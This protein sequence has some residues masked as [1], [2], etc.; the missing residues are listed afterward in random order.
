M[1]TIASTAALLSFVAMGAPAS[2][3]E[4]APADAEASADEQDGSGSEVIE[5]ARS[6]EPG[7][8]H[9]V[10]EA[11]L[12]RF[13]H[14]DIHQILATVPGVYFREE[15][16][17]GLRPNIGMRGTD[18][19]R[20]AKV[21]LMEDGILIAPAPYS[22]PAAYYFPLVTRMSAVEVVKGPGTVVYGPNTVGG[23][24]NLVSQEVPRSGHIGFVDVAGGDSLYGK[25]HARYGMATSY[26][27]FLVEG[28]KL[29]SN[30]FKD[31]DG[32]GNTGF[33][34]TDLV[35]KGRLQSNPAH[36][37]FH[38]VNLTI[39]YADEDSNETYTG[40]SDDDFAA[41][42]YRRYRGTALDHMS[43]DHLRWQLSHRV[44]IGSDVDVQTTLY[45]NS[46]NRAWRKLNGFRGDSDLAGILANPDAG[47]N[48]IF[49]G[50]LRGDSDTSSAAEELLIGTNDRRFVSQGLQTV[51]HG[52]KQVWPGKHDLRLGVRLH[53][54]QADRHHSEDP[55]AMIGGELMSAGTTEI[56]TDSLAMASA[57]ATFLQD[58]IAMG[59]VA[60]TLG[61]RI[62]LVSTELVDRMMAT[63]TTDHYFV[64]I[65]GA[66]AYYKVVEGVGL[67]AGVHKGFVPVAPGAGDGVR[68]ED[69]LNYETGVRLSRWG[70][71][72]EAIGFFT[73]YRNLK[74]SCTFS[75]G[76]ETDQLGQEFN[77]GA[78]HTLG[79]E[80]MIQ[81][82]PAIAPELHLLMRGSY[83]FTRSTFQSDFE[84]DNPQWGSVEAGDYLPYLPQ[85]QLSGTMGLQSAS[86]ELSAALRFQ[87]AMRNHAG[88]G[89]IPD[90]E[91]IPAYAVADL[92][93]SYDFGRWGRAYLT[94]DNVF[95]QPY[96]VSYR[97]YGAR[98]GKPRIA[99]LGYKNRF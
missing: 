22:A 49:F 59:P 88:Q 2:A 83:T 39:G 19:E 30:G 68:P 84:S 99:I 12:E 51:I 28:V 58:Q 5:V 45:R 57:A 97:P 82:S 56:T 18:P 8:E 75:S 4:Q 1:R 79:V 41:N 3:D 73:D 33:D 71:G 70:I 63:T 95:D 26:A 69:S 81:A 35:F 32:G 80:S 54:D 43:W 21:A 31:L 20:S 65:P 67:L 61:S 93:G 11:E 98:P 14:D 91:R 27:G 72:A 25:L 17:F 47:N 29:H 48:P 42:P 6:V 7:S 16:G 52:E 78:V 23:S 94:I 55:Y 76:C 62:E 36:R 53:R 90:G 87:G 96:L 10:S 24:V 74:G 86:W 77:G 40:L 46:F 64:W 89:T 50:V 37:T 92:A 85:H 13:E 60:L 15:D 66:G 44:E 38:Q 34:K 9:V